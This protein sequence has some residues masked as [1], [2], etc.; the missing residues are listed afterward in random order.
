MKV[1]NEE[2]DINIPDNSALEFKNAIV[3]ELQ[4]L[5]KTPFAM[6]SWNEAKQKGQQECLRDIINYL[7]YVI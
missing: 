6:N 2:L 5:I 1:L 3:Q 4:K 7:N